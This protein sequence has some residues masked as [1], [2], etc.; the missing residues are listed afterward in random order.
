MKM[1]PEGK[2]W[3]EE[4]HWLRHLIFLKAQEKHQYLI[5][6]LEHNGKIKMI[7]VCN[8]S[9]I[10]VPYVLFLGKSTESMDDSPFHASLTSHLRITF[11][12]ESS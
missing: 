7:Q 6:A 9:F 3:K 11:L 2:D 4:E 12:H 8:L 10:F 1:L 5:L